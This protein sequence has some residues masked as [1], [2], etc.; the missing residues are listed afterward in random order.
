MIR[1]FGSSALCLSIA[2]IAMLATTTSSS[3]TDE[4][5]NARPSSTRGPQPAASSSGGQCRAPIGPGAESSIG[6]AVIERSAPG[7]WRRDLKFSDPVVRRPNSG[8]GTVISPEGPTPLRKPGGGRWLEGYRPTTPKAQAEYKQWLEDNAT[9]GSIETKMLR[10]D[11]VP[12]YQDNLFNPQMAQK[13]GGTPTEYIVR[14]D[15]ATASVVDP[16]TMPLRA[17]AEKDKPQSDFN[18]S[19][20]THDQYR[21]LK[22]LA[23]NRTEETVGAQDADLTPATRAP[24]PLIMSFDAIGAQGGVPPDPI[25]AA[26]RSHVVAVVNSHYQVYDKTG[27]AL[28]G[29]IAVDDLFATVPQCIG[30]FDPFIDYDEEADRFVM[31]MDDFAGNDSY[32]CIAATQTGD[33]TGAWNVYSFRSD[34]MVPTTGSDF[35]HMGIGLDAVYIS[36]NMFNDGGGY[37][38]IRVWAVSKTDLYAGTPLTVAEANLSSSPYFT[39]QPVKIHGFLSGGWPAPGTPHY[40]VSHNG[41]STVRL[42]SWTDPFN[43]APAMYGDVSSTNNGA[44]PNAPEL[45]G[46]TLNDTSTADFLDAEYRGGFLYTTR[47]V[48]CN[49][50]GGA[51]ESC[52]DWLKI[53]VSG[54]SPSLA[55]Q[56]SGGAYGSANQ[57]RYYPDISVDR[58]ENIAIG[59]TKSASTTY[60][61]VWVTGREFGDPVG[62]LQTETQQRAGLGNYTDG[63]GCGGTCDRWGDYSGMTVDPDGCTFWYIG[64]FSDGGF[65][66]WETSIGAYKFP[67]CSVESL[68]NLSKATF[69]CG[70]ELTVTV[71]DS[72]ALTEA[73]VSAQTVVTTSSGDSETIPVGKWQGSGCTGNACTQWSS[74]LPTSGDAGANDDGVVNVADSGTITVDYTD[75][76]PGHSNQSRT[77]NVDCQTRFDDGGFLIDGGCEN[78][79]GTELYREY[80]DAGELIAYTAGFFNPPSAPA[81]TDVRASLSLTGDA[82]SMVTIYNPTVEVGPVGQG[83]LGGAVFYLL[84]DPG[85]DTASLR[86]TPLSLNINLTSPADG[87]TVPQVLVQDQFVQAD[88]NIVEL[89]ECFNFEAD[90]Q[91]FTN[92]RYEFSYTCGSAEGCIPT[93]VVNTVVAPWTRGGGCFSET[94]TDQPDPSCDVGGTFAFKSNFNLN[95]C[96]PFD[97]S[98]NELT[99]D[100]LYSPIFSPV[101]TG[102]AGTNQPWQFRWK[103]AD[104]F[105][106]SEHEDASGQTGA[107]YAHFWDDN[108]T[109]PV[110]PDP[111]ENETY[112][113]FLGFFTYG[114]QDWDSGTPW[115]PMN[116]PANYD[117][118]NFPATASGEATPGLNWRWVHELFDTDFG[119][120]PEATV[121]LNGTAID[122]MQLVYDQYHLMEQIGICSGAAGTVAFDQFAYYECPG[123]DLGVAVLDANAG[124][125]VTVTVTSDGTGDSE[126]FSIAGGGPNYEGTMAYSTSDGTAADDGI[127]YVTPQ[128]TVRVSYDDTNPVETVTNA[129]FIDCP[130][131]NVV[132]VGVAGLQDDGNGD[133]DPHADQ[134]ETVDLSLTL[135]NDTSG[136]LTNV[137]AVISTNDPSI[138]CI[139]KAEASFG[140]ITP[141]GG[142]ASNNLATDPFTFQVADLAAQCTDP[143]TTPTPSFDVFIT[144]DGLIAADAPQA[145]SLRLDVNDLGST[146]VLTEDFDGAQPAGWTHGVG[147]GDEDGVLGNGAGGLPCS[148]Y[149][150]NWF[151]RNSGGNTGGGFFC[152]NDPADN[153]PNG[154]YDDLLDA[155]LISPAIVIPA[156]GTSATLTFD[157]E[158]KFADANNPPLLADGAVVYYRVNG[159]AWIKIDSLPY[160]GPLIW[161]TYCNPLCNGG[162]SLFDASPPATIDCSTE[163]NNNGENVF[164]REFNATVNWTTAQATVLG[165]SGA[166]T[167]EFRWRVGSMNGATAFGLDTSGG[168]G[169]DNVQVDSNSQECDSA[170]VVPSNTCSLGFE[171]AS[172][173]TQQCGDGDSL[174]EPG[175]EWSVDVRLINDTESTAVNTVADLTVNAGGVQATVSGNPG[176]YG[177]LAPKAKASETYSFIVDQGATCVDDIDFDVTNIMDNATMHPDELNAFAVQ[178][179]G[180]GVQETGFQGTDPLDSFGAIA[181]SIVS[182]QFSLVSAD[183]AT[184]SYDFQALFAPGTEIASQDTP[185]NN[186]ISNSAQSTL[187][188]EFNIETTT[189]TAASVSWTSLISNNVDRCTR[190]TLFA[191]GGASTIL[192]NLL[193]PPA[194]PYDVLAFYNTNGPGQYTIELFDSGGGGCQGSSSLAGTTMSVDGGV[195]GGDWDSNARVYLW[196]GSTQTIV[197]D[198]GEADANPYDVTG[199]YTGGGQYYEVRLE[200]QGNETHRITNAQMAIAQTSCD[201]SNCVAGV[202]PPPLGDDVVGTGIRLNKGAGA[203]DLDI[204]FDNVT[205]S[206]DHA[207]VVYGNIGDFTGYQGAVDAGCNLGASGSGT[208]THAGD[209]VWFNVLWVTGDDK[210]GHPGYDSGPFIRPWNAVG[211]CGATSDDQS[212]PVCN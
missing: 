142:T 34:V 101:N 105:F 178:V 14:T 145:F 85:V 146:V 124:A 177:T 80:L 46:G 28:T 16:K 60:T 48:F 169:L 53:D 179:G 64:E 190:V 156:G 211:L 164:N 175:E 206:E 208:F 194:I 93:R 151:W 73:E 49:I 160:D 149:G 32:F 23:A 188:P 130:G 29:V 33:P 109:G 96:T 21:E 119:G 69:N 192:K 116:P 162:E 120:D 76:H 65:A 168:Y 99:D 103:Y 107:A 27:A 143:G 170:V 54:A 189:T 94:R 210:A 102:D 201:V 39:A 212:D 137:K 139:L 25:M 70:E 42:W 83:Q 2:T 128:D 198:F 209:N 62:T 56:Q 152:W 20:L 118:V 36:A 19:G 13:G 79:E 184:L 176:Q 77:V 147:P 173:L 155:E 110:D 148:P 108:Y 84:V 135:R 127:L 10:S 98:N 132:V 183:T 61:E 38:H 193:E 112:P 191:P 141:N 74:K 100:L 37:S 129:A 97:Q 8:A 90:A 202:V 196:D 58:A 165:L 59:Y 123:G 106:F 113:W 95:S 172:N 63:V 3:A 134:N 153:F 161:N 45:G 35:P 159:G 52:I 138:G 88:D 187:S 203:N 86:M 125:S 6:R 24:S 89:S 133:G 144:A 111:N 18:R 72:T 91:G 92:E 174:V 1:R 207:I 140:T 17:A 51:A 205:C 78:G 87:F 47:A 131:G 166:D 5:S 22:E 163:N 197:K 104:W 204:T 180:V 81:L 186:V 55:E 66:A 115:D 154:T 50:G 7:T 126:T 43:L 15:V 185:L 11:E 57:F 200:T 12:S 75:L 4:G 181:G 44:P 9:V 158:Y 82:A 171:S 114:N 122:N 195:A 31:G 199:L 157:H 167:I 30:T 182:P 41:S 26:G 136:P 71:D 150:D 117:S 40:F 67:S 68:V 121:A